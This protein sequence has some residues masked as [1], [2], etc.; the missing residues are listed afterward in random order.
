[1]RIEL[2]EQRAT[3]PVTKSR[4]GIGQQPPIVL[5]GESECDLGEDEI[6]LRR[7]ELSRSEVAVTPVARGA[8]RALKEAGDR[9]LAGLALILLAPVL[10]VIAALVRCSSP[11]PILFRQTR[12][13][14]GGMPF[15]FLKFR[16]MIDGAEHLVVDLRDLNDCD[17]VL[18][19]IREDPRT[20]AVGR[21]LRRFSLDEL[22]QLWN[23]LKGDMSLVG[24]RPALPAEV[25]TYCSRAEK[26]LMV[27]PGLT[28]LWQVSGR[29]NLCWD[30]AITLDVHYVE[31]QSL[32]LDLSILVKTVP[33]VVTGRGAY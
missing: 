32:S 6:D 18:F 5:R 2:G 19:K 13:G 29:S 1:M 15:R 27:K 4:A 21:W 24:P 23:V 28:G 10:L 9:T 25:A 16:T 20:T 7:S 3:G 26:R 11:G 30:K 14:Q 31:H 8:Y 22:P 12:I 33:A 17:D